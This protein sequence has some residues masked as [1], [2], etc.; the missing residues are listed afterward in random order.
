MPHDINKLDAA[1]GR[2]MTR[3]PTGEWTCLGDKVLTSCCCQNA[4]NIVGCNS[5]GEIWQWDGEEWSCLSTNPVLNVVSV[6][7]D[8]AMYGVEASTWHI[9]KWNGTSWDEI[10]GAAPT[11]AAYS[12]TLI[13]ALTE[14]GLYIGDGEG[15]WTLVDSTVC[16]GISVASDGSLFAIKSSDGSLVKWSGSAWGSS[17]GAATGLKQIAAKSGTMVWAVGSDDKLW[18]WNGLAWTKSSDD[19]V[20]GIA[21]AMM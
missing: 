16:S 15:G 18:Y 12:D 6:G 19:T 1:T 7:C 2:C 17:L 13:Y 21:L 9:Q 4:N 10:T 3:E 8:G 20:S 11:I 5:S 14:S